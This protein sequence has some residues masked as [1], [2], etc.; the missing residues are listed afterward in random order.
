MSLFL[1]SQESDKLKLVDE[2]LG[3]VKALARDDM[4]SDEEVISEGSE[5]KRAKRPPNGFWLFQLWQRQEWKRKNLL[6]PDQAKRCGELWKKMSQED[7]HTWS[8]QSYWIDQSLRG[9]FFII[10][11]I[12]KRCMSVW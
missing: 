7:K 6:V 1:G 9:F 3:K 12:R 5:E 2:I 4:M 10:I 8:K 11:Q